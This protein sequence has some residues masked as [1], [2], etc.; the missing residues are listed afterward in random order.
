M[1][2]VSPC[3]S[4]RLQ[5]WEYVTKTSFGVANYYTNPERI[6]INEK[7]FEP[8]FKDLLEKII[9]HEREHHKTK[10]FWKQRKV[11]AMT[12]LSFKDLFPFYRK[13]PKTFFQQHSPITY[14]DNTLY[15]EWSLIFLYLIYL[16]IGFLIFWIINTFSTSSEMFLKIVGYSVLIIIISIVILKG[17][18][19][20]INY[21]NKQSKITTKK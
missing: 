5:S 3:R 8:E 1:T 10:G 19:G 2:N 12:E 7:L 6:E 11:D 13:Y 18:K 4:P 9:K 17:G 20:L 15:F 14:Q 16:S 21:T